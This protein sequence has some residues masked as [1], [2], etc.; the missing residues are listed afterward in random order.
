[1]PAEIVRIAEIASGDIWCRQYRGVEA[2]R[3]DEA[4]IVFPTDFGRK[5]ECLGEMSR[6][7]RSSRAIVCGDEP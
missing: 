1:M 6:D 5:Y 3:L 2:R 4:D 7:T